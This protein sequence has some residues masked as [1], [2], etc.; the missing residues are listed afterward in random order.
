MILEIGWRVDNNE[1][2]SISCL[3][4][5]QLWG[6]A[7]KLFPSAEFEKIL[8]LYFTGKL[9]SPLLRA[10]ILTLNSY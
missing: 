9:K 7:L 1:L 4:D 2:K 10:L 8:R 6:Y 3:N 5:S